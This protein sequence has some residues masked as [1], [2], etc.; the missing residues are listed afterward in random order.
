MG[1]LP[2]VS[3]KVASPSQKIAVKLPFTQ[4]A[5]TLKLGEMLCQL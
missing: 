3:I 1:L 2:F 4:P 5:T